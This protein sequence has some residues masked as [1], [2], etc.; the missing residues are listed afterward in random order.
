MR[1]ERILVAVDT[2]NGRDAAFER[3]LTLARPSGA[4]LYVLHAVPA[5]QP[6]SRRAAERLARTEALRRRAEEAGV[7]VRV[8]EQHGDPAAIIDLHANARAVD[9][10]VMGTEPRRWWGRRRHSSVAERVLRQTTRPTLVV[11][12][13]AP[14]SRSSF[15]NVLAAVDLSPASRAFLDTAVALTAPELRQLTV[16]HA[17]K[18]L[19]PDSA[20]QSPSRWMVPEYRTYILDDA[21]RALENV[22][23]AVRPD[24][25]VRIATGPAANAIVEEAANVDADVVIVGTGRRFKP[26]GSL[27]ARVLRKG[28]RALLVIPMT[29]RGSQDLERPRAA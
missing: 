24:A 13:H 16:V 3:A 1:L 4:E 2:T 22:V 15:A 21:R 23:S 18:G 10:I 17:V 11:A 26:L 6:F 5:H 12:S 27:A 20:V 29:A 14:E 25:D 9:L 19:E 7:P 8:A 28:A